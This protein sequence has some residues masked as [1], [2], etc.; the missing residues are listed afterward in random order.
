[1]CRIELD[2]ICVSGN[3]LCIC[4]VFWKSGVSVG[5]FKE[6]LNRLSVLISAIHYILHQEAQCKKRLQIGKMGAT[7]KIKYLQVRGSQ[8][9]IVFSFERN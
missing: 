3:R 2:K 5:F 1:M 6:K 4:Y 9:P 8:P 7:V